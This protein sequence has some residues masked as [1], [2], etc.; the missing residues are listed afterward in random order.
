MDRRI[1][2]LSTNSLFYVLP[3][4]TVVINVLPSMDVIYFTLQK[5]FRSPRR[6][7][8]RTLIIHNRVILIDESSKE[9]KEHTKESI[10]IV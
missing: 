8:L 5:I 3:Q 10:E 6:I 7:Y 1:I 9:P 2:M 4:F